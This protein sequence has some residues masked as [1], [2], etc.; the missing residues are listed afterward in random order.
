MR[1]WM[2]GL[3]L[4]GMTWGTIGCG[5][6]GGEG[7]APAGTTA[8]GGAKLPGPEDAGIDLPVKGKARR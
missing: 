8:P 5:E 1:R 4:A 7:Q 6:S 3:L 2:V